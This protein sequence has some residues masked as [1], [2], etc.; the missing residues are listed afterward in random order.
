M[1]VMSSQKHALTP[2]S[3]NLQKCQH[4]KLASVV[5]WETCIRRCLFWT[6]L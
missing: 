6:L 5:T 4:S 3:I 1:Y 2:A